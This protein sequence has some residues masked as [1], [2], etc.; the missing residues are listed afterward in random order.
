MQHTRTQ[1][2]G[3]DGSPGPAGARSSL[4][5]HPPEQA[6]AP[7][8]RNSAVKG[9]PIERLLRV[10]I[11]DRAPSEDDAKLVAGATSSPLPDAPGPA[12]APR[13]HSA[14][15]QL[16]RAAEA[17]DE[18]P[19][20]EEPSERLLAAPL[21]EPSSAPVTPALI[22]ASLDTPK[23]PTPAP[24]PG[25]PSSAQ[26]PTAAPARQLQRPEQPAAPVAAVTAG[27]PSAEHGNE[28]P[29]L[30]SPVASPVPARRALAASGVH[31]S[32]TGHVLR[33]D[34]GSLLGLAAEL[35]AASR[36]S[37][38]AGGRSSSRLNAADLEQMA[39]A[40][41]EDS[42]GEEDGESTASD[43]KILTLEEEAAELRAQLGIVPVER[44]LPTIV[45]EAFAFNRAKQEEKEAGGGGARSELL[46]GAETRRR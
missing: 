5:H 38:L 1:S 34:S 44:D 26:S 25:G 28:E 24:V 30:A 27:V 29:E 22:R 18:E 45:R 37:S 32:S 4:P 39:R 40:E 8:A 14:A 20:T 43:A 15:A 16:L 10:A 13:H 46:H 3:S 31:K 12:P 33:A 17:V 23:A 6:R 11:P 7:G 36:D 35:R 2:N 19:P 21:V 42:E 41:A 9:S